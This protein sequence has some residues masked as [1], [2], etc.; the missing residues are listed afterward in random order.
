MPQDI[1]V[2]QR[3]ASSS[4]AGYL[5]TVCAV[6]KTSCINNRSNKRTRVATVVSLSSRAEDLAVARGRDRD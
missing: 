5:S 3:I 4:L 2:C 1:Y 6:E